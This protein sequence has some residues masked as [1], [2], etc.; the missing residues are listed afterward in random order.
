MRVQNK[1]ADDRLQFVLGVFYTDNRQLSIEE[2]RDPE[3]P[4]LIPLIF[5]QDFLTF[6]E[7]FPL[8]A[9][10]DSYINRSVG[11][12]SQT[13]I[14]GDVTFA[15]TRQLKLSAGL[16]YAWTRFSFTNFADGPQNVGQ[17]T[18]AGSKRER[19]LT[20]KFNVSWQ[21]HASPT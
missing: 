16:R 20:P 21:R 10:G 6:T 18:G 19:P 5:G 9:N 1:S 14:F 13:A 4:Q 12:D 11:H 3:L 7:G 15:L 2:I 17:S 8:L